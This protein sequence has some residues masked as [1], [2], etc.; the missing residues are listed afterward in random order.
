MDLEGFQPCSS[1][2][3]EVSDGVRDGFKSHEVGGS[4]SD[5]A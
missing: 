1:V 4:D 3:S 2:F 5:T